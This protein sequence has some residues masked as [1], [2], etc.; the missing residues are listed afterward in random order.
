MFRFTIRE[1]ILLTVI[2]AMG[3]AWWVDHRAAASREETAIAERNK[4]KQDAETV[5]WMAQF[6][7][8]AAERLQKTQAGEPLPELP[9]ISNLDS[10]PNH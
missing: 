6:F 10:E 2:V 9:S 7:R 5:Y 3:A 1:L 4:A 8:R